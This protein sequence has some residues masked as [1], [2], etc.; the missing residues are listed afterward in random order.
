METRYQTLED[1][2]LRVRTSAVLPNVAITWLNVQHQN[3]AT[4]LSRTQAISI[5]RKPNYGGIPPEFTSPLV[6][7]SDY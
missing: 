7:K 6:L 3:M 5:A 1:F 4:P 2:P